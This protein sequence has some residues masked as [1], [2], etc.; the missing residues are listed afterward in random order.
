MASPVSL[1]RQLGNSTTIDGTTTSVVF[2]GSNSEFE[3]FANA[4]VVIPASLTATIQVTNDIPDASG[5]TWTNVAT[6]VTNKPITDPYLITVPA[7]GIKVVRTAGSGVVTCTILQSGGSSTV[8][9]S[10]GN[11][12]ATGNVASGATDSGNPVKI[13]GVYNTTLP[14]LTNGQRGDLQ[15]D[16]SA[17]LITT[18][19]TRIAGENL[20]A[21]IN[22]LMTAPSY[23][24]T[25]ITSATTT[26]AKSGEGII[27]GFFVEVAL[28]GTVTVYNNT[29]GSG[30]ILTILPIGTVAGYHPF[31]ASFTT[32]CTAV[33]SAADRVVLLTV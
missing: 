6:G 5:A 3:S 12:T 2:G 19:G 30:T 28:T 4:A 1:T 25:R 16:A 32:G 13:G 11:V 17:E 22:R 20:G 8:T 21:T 31:P 7:R 15:V 18:L 23:T 9:I 33:T 29:A 10:S 14:T 26:T 24:A 27:G